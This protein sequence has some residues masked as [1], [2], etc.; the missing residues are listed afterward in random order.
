MLDLATKAV[1]GWLAVHGSE[2]LA[3][4]P[5]RA[6]DRAELASTLVALG[7]A[8][9][10]SVHGGVEPLETALR[11]GLSSSVAEVIAHLGP[12]RRLRLLHWLTEAG[13]EHPDRVIDGIAD[14]G[15]PYGAAI[16]SWMTA[17]LR[18]EQ[19]DRLFAAERIEMLITACRNAG[20]K[21]NTP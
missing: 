20:L 18:R 2:E 21:E 7:K 6:D 4:T 16:L 9:D 5:S 11:E 14:P 3:R 8:M 12:A 13:F 17:L 1:A 15:T 10:D 19:L